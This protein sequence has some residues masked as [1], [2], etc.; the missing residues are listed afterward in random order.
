KRSGLHVAK[1][2]LH[3]GNV[4]DL[5]LARHTRDKN[6]T[7]LPATLHMPPLAGE[8]QQSEAHMRSL[9]TLSLLL[10]STASVMSAEIKGSSRI[11]AVTVYPSGAEVMRVGRV[12]MEGGEHVILF[13]DLPAQALPGSL[14][15]EGR[16]TG[17]LDIGS[18]D[19][20][21]VSVPRSDSAVAATER[22]QTEAAIEKLKDERAVLQAAVEAGQAQKAL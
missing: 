21:R 6:A 18:V 16:A 11:D 17:T 8:G 7:R 14:R 15:V 3:R 1:Q 13:T 22:R 9:T 5:N 19:T 2:T 20:R 10:A 4:A 12:T